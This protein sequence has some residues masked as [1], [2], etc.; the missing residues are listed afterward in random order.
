M[1][2]ETTVLKAAAMLQEIKTTP[3][4]AWE[5]AARM[6]FPNSVSSQKKDCPKNTFLAIC[7]RGWVKSVK[8]GSYTKSEENKRYA[9][10]AVKIL[11]NSRQNFTPMELWQEVLK[12]E[13][14]KSKK[15]NSQMNVVLA[16]VRSEFILSS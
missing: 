16:L 14:D 10:K 15:H 13:P 7:E 11:Q 12:T 9:I 3:E 6:I 2:Y 5:R 4:L 8:P 1:S